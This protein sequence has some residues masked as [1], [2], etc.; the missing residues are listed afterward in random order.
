M[1]DRGKSL[2]QANPTDQEGSYWN[3]ER[4][5]KSYRSTMSILAYVYN[6]FER[7][8]CGITGFLFLNFLR[9]KFHTELI[10]YLMM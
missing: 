10:R 2:R 6:H 7:I 5:K 9:E 1:I 3:I 8:D 4:K